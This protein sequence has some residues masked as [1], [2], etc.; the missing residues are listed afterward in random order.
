[1]TGERRY[2]LDGSVQSW[3][4]DDGCVVI[5]GSPLTLFRLTSAGARTFG[6]LADGRA[7]GNSPLV[8]RLL[9]AGAIHPLLDATGT[10][11]PAD[12]TIVV[13][14]LGPP[15]HAP[16]SAV[17]VDDG[18][19]PPV[20]GATIRLD[21]NRGPAAAR[22]AGLATVTTP[23]VAFVD[24]D[25]ALPDGWLDP[26]LPHFDDP[27]VAVVAPRIVTAGRPGAI[28]AY[29]RTH[30]PLDM[31]PEAARVRAGTR[32]SYLPAAVLVCRTEAIRAVGGFDEAMR[33]GEDVDLVWRLD[34]AGRRCRYDPSSVIEHE[35]RPDWR[36]W[37]AQRVGYGSS[38]GP[39][40]IRHPGKLAP[41]R[42]SGW[43]VAT[44][45]L[46]V[47]GRPVAGAAVGVGS[48]A[49]LI[50]KLPDVPPRAA[51]RLAASGNARAGEAIAHAVRRTWFPIVAV[52]A[53]R[54][55]LARRVLF[56]SV[57]AVRHPIALADDVTYCIG[58]WKGMVTERTLDP[59][60][61]EITSWPGRRATR[62]VRREPGRRRA[63]RLVRP[64]RDADVR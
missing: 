1:M 37:V 27:K 24:A 34:D 32:V 40:A 15:A 43:S 57:V 8:D 28:S 4:N 56:A 33:F 60:V 21:R 2:A 3:P 19:L 59:I 23:L 44:W 50:P 64:S 13:P 52:M 45:M 10:Y 41:L 26:L 51:F 25:V 63:L 35:P 61:P 16:T 12:V 5:G 48:A 39:L 22:N 49:A 31:G 6:D 38:A 53:L 42:M 11:S 20:E 17:I 7:V 14:T 46:T 9:D 54:S 36:S 29:E 58:V 55:R 18:S 62:A 30:G 47:L